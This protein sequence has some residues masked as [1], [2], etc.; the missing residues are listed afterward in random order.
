VELR[1]ASILRSVRLGSGMLYGGGGALRPAP[2]PPPPPRPLGGAAGAWDYLTWF[3]T[4][5]V[6]RSSCHPNS[7]LRGAFFHSVGLFH[8]LYWALLAYLPAYNFPP[9]K[10]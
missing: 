1:P 6:P 7:A 4:G 8:G 2:A 3:D 5:F 9:G 10:L